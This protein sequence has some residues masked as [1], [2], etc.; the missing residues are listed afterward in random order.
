MTPARKWAGFSRWFTASVERRMR[1][2]FG[3]MRVAGL[4]RLR[5]VA[6]A[7]PVLFVANHSAWWDPLVALVVSERLLGIDGYAL[8][9]E[10]NLERLRFFALVGGLGVRLGQRRDG[11]RA[12][13]HAATL[14]D[15]PGRALWIYPQGSEQP[16]GT[17]LRFQPGAAGLA[18]RVARVAVIPVAIRYVFAATP[19]PELVVVF[20]APLEGTEVDTV[21]LE[22]S[23][24]DALQ[25][26]DDGRAMADTTA[27]WERRASGWERLTTALLDRF[28]GFVLARFA[29]RL[30][31]AIASQSQTAIGPAH[32]GPHERDEPN[33]Q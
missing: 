29:D 3:A 14:L 20:G 31:P 22:R 24:A 1:A 6:A 18:R 21:L 15:R 10:S 25:R 4:E 19:A 28:A 30:E 27:I 5:E 26:I 8:M 2:S 32:V 11:A 13:A 16:I 23:V 12:L 17:P 9:D 33:A 7:R